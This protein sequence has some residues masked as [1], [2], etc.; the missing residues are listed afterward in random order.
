MRESAFWQLVKKNLSPAVHATRI[1]NSAG[2]GQ[3]D[4][5]ACRRGV[6]AW[7]ELKIQHGNF[8]EFRSAQLQ[9]I[10]ARLRAG[11]RVVVLAEHRGAVVL[12][13]G[14]VCFGTV[15]YPAKPVSGKKAVRVRADDCYVLLRTGKPF[16]WKSIEAKIFERR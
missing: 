3:S 15:G 14:G 13:H 5:N 9:W 2:A 7:V 8:L 11:G 16:D 6:E 12:Y 10:G 4:V 1:E